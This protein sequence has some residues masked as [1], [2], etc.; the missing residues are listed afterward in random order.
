M[1]KSDYLCE[2]TEGI[3]YFDYSAIL[4][5]PGGMIIRN[6]DYSVNKI[7]E[8]IINFTRRFNDIG[9]TEDYKIRRLN[10]K[11]TN[12]IITSEGQLSAPA[13]G[14]IASKPDHILTVKTAD[15][16]PVFI[17]DGR[18]AALLH[19]GWRGV[20]SGIISEFFHAASNLNL[21]NL[22][23]LV[24]PG[25]GNCCFEVSPEVFILFDERYRRTRDRKYFVDVRSLIL[26]ELKKF[27]VKYVVD[28]GVCTSC[29]TDLFY[30]YRREGTKVK[31]MISF[32]STGG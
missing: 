14:I 13:D 19:A 6:C 15:C 27:G 4:G 7:N 22:K 8:F 23:A 32:I 31:Q 18:T 24:A 16:F 10:Q 26:D 5:A 1:I 28:N 11:H 25:I 20:L 17:F 30:S 2:S 29:N 21:N 3:R 12:N 9:N